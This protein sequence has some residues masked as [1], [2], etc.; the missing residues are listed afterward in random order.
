MPSVVPFTPDDD[1]L[2]G[3]TVFD[4]L[5]GHNYMGG[6]AMISME[7][8]RDALSLPLTGLEGDEEEDGGLCVGAIS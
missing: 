6:E 3:D 4:G 8:L 1:E 7:S 2:A 5:P